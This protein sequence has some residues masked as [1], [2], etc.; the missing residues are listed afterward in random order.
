[1]TKVAFGERFAGLGLKS[2]EPARQRARAK[3]SRDDSGVRLGEQCLQ[4]H[5][6]T[7][8]QRSGRTYRQE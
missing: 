4:L 6:V 2:D 3:M 1:M 8:F 7:G 5:A